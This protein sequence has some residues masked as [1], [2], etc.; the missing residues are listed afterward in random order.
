MTLLIM[1]FKIKKFKIFN[2][3]NKHDDDAEDAMFGV[4]VKCDS[5]TLANKLVEFIRARIFSGGGA[6]LP[7]VVMRKRV[8]ISAGLRSTHCAT[9]SK[10]VSGNVKPISRPTDSARLP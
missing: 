4:H 7:C 6:A 3:T 10:I 5:L 9:D 8:T 2:N 1:L